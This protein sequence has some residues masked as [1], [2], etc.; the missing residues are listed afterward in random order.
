ML[1]QTALYHSFY[2]W[3]IFLVCTYHL[4]FIYS[5]ADGNL[6]CFH[7]LAVVNNAAMNI[8]V[9]IS[10]LT[11]VFSG[12]TPRSG[13]AGSYGSFIFI[14]LRNLNAVLYSGCSSLQS[15]QLQRRVPFSPHPLQHLL[16]IDFFNDG[17][18]EEYE[19]I[20]P[21]SFDLHFSID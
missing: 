11:M 18:S 12:Y 15:L 7:V 13:I 2:G 14:L 1:L 21:C 9:S 8:T 6:G 17:H 16:F 19:V 10:F 3:V 5:S 4:F 20:P